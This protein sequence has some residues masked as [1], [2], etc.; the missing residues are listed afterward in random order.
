MWSTVVQLIY[1]IQFN[2][3]VDLESKK[4]TYSWYFSGENKLSAF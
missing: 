2:A 3:D 1:I 4:S